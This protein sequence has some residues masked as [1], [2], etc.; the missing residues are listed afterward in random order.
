MDP[1]NELTQHRYAEEKPAATAEDIIAALDTLEP[2]AD[3]QAAMLIAATFPALKQAMDR[4]NSKQRILA[5]LS[6][7][8]VT[9][10]PKKFDRLFNA[11]L[12]A[13][14]ERGERFC[15]VTCGQ[16]ITKQK[17]RGSTSVTSSDH[18]DRAKRGEA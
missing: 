1:V 18:D 15:C 16:S 14:N 4:G 10:H 2:D 7:K 11:E 6:D 8:G 12:N 17:D 3:S 13:R 9:L 5:L